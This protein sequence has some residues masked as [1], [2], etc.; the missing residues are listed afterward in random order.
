[1][2]MRTI[3]IRI[4]IEGIQIPP[5]HPER[6]RFAAACQYVHIPIDSR[7]WVCYTK[8]LSLYISICAYA[9]KGARERAST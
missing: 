8:R 4:Y 3:M 5:T 7:P 9:N 2:R 6:V 1:M